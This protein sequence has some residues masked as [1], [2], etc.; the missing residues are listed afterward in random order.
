MCV[1]CVVC[2]CVRVRVRVC[3]CMRVCTVFGCVYCKYSNQ[4]PLFEPNMA[5]TT[6]NVPSSGFHCGSDCML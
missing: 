6:V 4:C 5:L 3:V 2:V 1:V